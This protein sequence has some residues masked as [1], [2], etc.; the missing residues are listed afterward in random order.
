M[1]VALYRPLDPST[2]I[3]SKKIV[4]DITDF[5]VGALASLNDLHNT[6]TF[7]KIWKQRLVGVG[8]LSYRDCLDLGLTGVMARSTGIKRDLR[9][10]EVD[11]YANYYHLSFRTY[12]GQKGDCYDRFLIRMNEIAESLFIIGQLLSGLNNKNGKDIAADTLD[13]ASQLCPPHLLENSKKNE[14]SSMEGLVSHFKAWSEGSPIE[15]G[16]TYRAVEAPKG[17]LGVTLIANGSNKPHRCKV[18]SPALHSLQALPRLAKG[19]SLADLSTLVGTVDIVFG[20]I[21]R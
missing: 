5:M 20:E 10:D 3:I 13:M 2:G 1:H 7:N 21:D 17:E 15:P 16:W 9:M 18:R 12:L 6:L 14:Y 19:H 11:T 4:D 8:A